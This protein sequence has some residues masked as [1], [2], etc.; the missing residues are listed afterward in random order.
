VCAS[1][2]SAPALEV[3]AGDSSPTSVGVLILPAAN[4][5]G[6]YNVTAVPVGGG[7][8]ITVTC[9]TPDCALTGLQPGTTYAVTT[10][11]T[12]SS[13][14]ATPA[15]TVTAVTT[16]AAGSPV[17]DVQATGTGS[18][19]VQV[20]PAPGTGGPYTVT[21]VPVGGGSPVTA[22]CPTADCTVSG[23][24]PDTT[25][26]VT[27]SGRDGNG[28]PTPPSAVDAVTTPKPG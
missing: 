1:A 9:A 25:Y 24:A 3:A 20:S 14:A 26:A 11:G 21:A 17:A 6:P 22:S 4:V 12:S 15:S 28:N 10:T 23:L 8:P 16:P 27:V 13:G 5:T 18:V 2:R 19:G 7:S